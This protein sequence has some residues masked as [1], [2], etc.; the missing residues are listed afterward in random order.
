MLHSAKLLILFPIFAVGCASFHRHNQNPE[1]EPTQAP[2]TSP[3]ASTA[4]TPAPV[5]SVDPQQTIAALN[6]KVETLELKVKSLTDAMDENRKQ[7][8]MENAAHVNPG[9]PNVGV[10]P[11]PGNQVGERVSSRTASTDPEAGFTNND[12]IQNFRK[13]FILFQSE[14]FPDAVVSFSAF[15]ENYPDHPLA[16]SA[17]YYVARCYLA[18]K[19]YQEAITE[20]QRVLTSYDRSPHIADTLRDLA[21]AEDALQKTQDAAKHRQLLTSLFPQSPAMI[22]ISAPVTVPAAVANSIPATVPV[23]ASTP[24]TP[25]PVQTSDI[26]PNA[27]L[28]AP[29]APEASK[30]AP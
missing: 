13:A 26:T 2:Q 1:P 8:A 5:P 28:D 6:A 15:L 17:Q 20:F 19:E 18:Q 22:P 24:S 30:K 21:S 7:Q 25:T 29:P 27:Q 14:K 12:A 11:K 10:V 4:Q 9:G 23:S 3:T 16:G